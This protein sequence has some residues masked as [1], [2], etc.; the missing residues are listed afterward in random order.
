M[1]L[2]EY[3]FSQLEKIIKRIELTLDITD[4]YLSNKHIKELKRII[5]KLKRDDK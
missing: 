4:L 2:N 3:D 5:R 1:E